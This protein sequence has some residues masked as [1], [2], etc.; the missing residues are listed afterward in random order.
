M[1]ATGN[2]VEKNSYLL[3]QGGYNFQGSRLCIISS[4]Q[5][6]AGTTLPG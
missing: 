1:H 5:D 2:H 3:R 6:P 4:E